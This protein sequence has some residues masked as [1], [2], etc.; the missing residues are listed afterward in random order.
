MIKNKTIVITGSEG[1]IGKD[2]VKY[3]KKKNYEI[4]G[5]DIVGGKNT[6]KCDITNEKVL[7]K[8]LDSKLKEI[9]PDILINAASKIPKINKFKFSSYNSQKWIKGIEVDLLGSFM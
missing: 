8:K 4:I 3:F 9:Q 6:I 2:I 5:I 1:L 7:K